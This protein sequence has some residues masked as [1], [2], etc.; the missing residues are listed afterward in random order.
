MTRHD[1]SD[2][3]SPA[4]VALIALATFSTSYNLPVYLHYNITYRR[5][6]VAML[7]CQRGADIVTNATR[8]TVRAPTV[9]DVCG[10]TAEATGKDENRGGGR[11]MKGGPS[12]SQDHDKPGPSRARETVNPPVAFFWNRRPDTKQPHTDDRS[13]TSQRY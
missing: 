9:L 3:D 5:A 6:F 13:G 2:A 11:D 4:N 10:E 8:S 1:S 12:V 7:R